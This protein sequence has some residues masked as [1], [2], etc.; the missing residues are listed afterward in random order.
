M[1]VEDS[2][3]DLGASARRRTGEEV[4]MRLASGRRPCHSPGWNSRYQRSAYWRR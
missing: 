2:A 3:E 1:F 4:R